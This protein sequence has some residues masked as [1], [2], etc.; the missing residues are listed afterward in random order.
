MSISTSPVALDPRCCVS[1]VPQ[2]GR[3]DHGSRRYGCEGRLPS[4]RFWLGRFSTRNRQLKSLTQL[5]SLTVDGRYSRTN[6]QL[7]NERHTLVE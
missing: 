5:S 4:F 1:A 2:A 7:E 3:V 6:A